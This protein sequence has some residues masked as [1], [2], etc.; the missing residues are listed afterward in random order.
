MPIV[1]KS[2]KLLIPSLEENNVPPAKPKGLVIGTPVVFEPFAL[3]EEEEPKL[4]GVDINPNPIRGFSKRNS[5]LSLS[6]PPWTQ[7]IQSMQHG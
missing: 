5:W 2:Q 4:G 7:F 3:E 6:E 1:D